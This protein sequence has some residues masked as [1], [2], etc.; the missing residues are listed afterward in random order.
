VLDDASILN[1]TTRKTVGDELKALEVRVYGW[2][3]GVNRLRRP[4]VAA[5]E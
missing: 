4:A 1:K 3:W 5:V 2:G